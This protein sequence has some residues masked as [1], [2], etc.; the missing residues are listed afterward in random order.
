MATST[1][2]QTLLK[3]AALAGAVLWPAWWMLGGHLQPEAPLGLALAGGIALFTPLLLLATVAPDRNGEHLRATKLASWGWWLAAPLGLL[4]LLSDPGT[5]AGVLAL[6]WLFCS[7]EVSELGARR[8]GRR[9]HP[10]LAETALDVALLS[11][12]VAGGALVA[13]R[14]GWTDAGGLVAAHAFGFG[15]GVPALAGLTG[16]GLGWLEQAGQLT[17]G[18]RGAWRV[19]AVAAL[20]GAV[21]TGA[22][23]LLGGEWLAFLG[24]L[25]ALLGAVGVGG[26]LVILGISGGVRRSVGLLLVLAGLVPVAT[27]AMGF[28]SATSALLG[29][30]R[31]PPSDVMLTWHGVASAVVFLGLGLAALAMQ[32]PP[33]LDPPAGAPVSGLRGGRTVGRFYFEAGGHRAEA[34]AP[35][36]GLVDD[37]A[38][39]AR[40]DVPGLHD[41]DPDAL[42]PAVRALFERTAGVRQDLQPQ[43]RKAWVGSLW[44]WLSGLVGQLELPTE[45]DHDR[46]GIV[47][48][49]LRGD[50][51]PGARG[52]VRA[53]GERTLWVASVAA[54]RANGVGW[55][56]AAF[57]L[58]GSNLSLL[59]RVDPGTHGGVV[60]TTRPRP[61]WRGDEAAWLVIRSGRWRLPL[62]VD[63]VVGPAVGE[64]DDD[65]DALLVAVQDVRVFG[66]QVLR[67]VH[68]L[69]PG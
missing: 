8:L 6:P 61:T 51:R 18:V 58:P 9:P 21:G 40:A 29:S 66:V 36:D 5:M 69:R 45:R 26:F 33:S 31:F 46:D 13:S 68:E 67:L 7:A 52:L 56:G 60:L 30:E 48:V 38:V 4:S 1:R 23:L 16:R 35:P 55:L 42:H 44:S 19:V 62:D 59:F 3:A 17:A 37:A 43:W 27:S 34:A 20:I 47:L 10:V 54:H 50:G 14:F 41:L 64:R 63:V 39:F 22:G 53:D 11:S 49:P 28:L 12:V 65:P 2:L 25:A 24:R 32:A 15:L 57:P